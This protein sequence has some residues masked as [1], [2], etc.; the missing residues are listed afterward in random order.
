[1]TFFRKFNWRI[2][3]PGMAISLALAVLAVM[4]IT[5]INEASYH[6]T[7]KSVSDMEKAQSTRGALNELMESLLDA[8]TGQRGYL[9]TGDKAYLEPYDERLKTINQQLDELRGTFSSNPASLNDFGVMSRHV[10][11]KLA[12]LDLTVK[13]RSANQEDAWRFVMTTDVGKEQ[14]DA[15]RVQINKLAAGFPARLVAAP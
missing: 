9:L 2:K 3:M 4:L 8:E 1:M 12:E 10:S 14:M 7:M 13:M 15:I 5:F 11:R 6:R